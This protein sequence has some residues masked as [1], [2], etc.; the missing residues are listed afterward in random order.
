MYLQGDIIDMLESMA[1][2][3]CPSRHISSHGR[4]LI[5][6]KELTFNRNQQP[7]RKLAPQ[8][9]K[10]ITTKKVQAVDVFNA[11]NPTTNVQSLKNL[12]AHSIILQ[13]SM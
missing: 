7:C 11:D 12:E 2:W 5:L 3:I 8:P 10:G 6:K 4:S 9:A 1:K 13:I